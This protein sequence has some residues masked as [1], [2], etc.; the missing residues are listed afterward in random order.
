MKLKKLL[1]DAV[2][3]KAELGL[4]TQALKR[5][6]SPKFK[7]TVWAERTQVELAIFATA[8][9]AQRQAVK[10]LASSLGNKR[11]CDVRNGRWLLNSIL[12]NKKKMFCLIK[13]CGQ[14]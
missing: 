1:L 13:R 11:P 8:V 3:T 5:L 2:A 9:A 14:A 12:K 10:V 7:P 6:D 4:A